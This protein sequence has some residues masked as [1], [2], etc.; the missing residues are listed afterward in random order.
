M[1][2]PILDRILV[3]LDRQTLYPLVAPSHAGQQPPDPAGH[4]AHMEQ[5]PDHMSNPI[6][7]PIIFCIP[8]SVRSFQQFPFQLFDLLFRQVC[9]FPR[10]SLALLRWVL[11]LLSPATDAAFGGSQLSGDLLERFTTFQQIQSF[12]ASFC[13]LFRCATWSHAPIILQSAHS[14]HFYVKTQ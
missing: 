2:F 7:R 5:L 14:G 4:I 10:A 3:S 13:K 11:R 6:Q 9:F 12:L 8:V 1:Y